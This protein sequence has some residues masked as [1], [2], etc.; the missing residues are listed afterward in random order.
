MVNSGVGTGT[1][2]EPSNVIEKVNEL[3][4]TTEENFQE[5]AKFFQE[6]LGTGMSEQQAWSRFSLATQ[7]IH[8]KVPPP[9]EPDEGNESSSD[10]ERSRRDKYPHKLEKY[11]DKKEELRRKM[12][13]LTAKERRARSKNAEANGIRDMGDVDNDADGGSSRSRSSFGD[14]SPEESVF[15]PSGSDV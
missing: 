5:L 3:L 2:G 7:H 10:H 13:H 4:K 12:R 6:V 8:V 9:A 15:Q 14:R 1:P 11:H